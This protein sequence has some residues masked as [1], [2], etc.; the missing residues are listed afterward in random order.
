[1]DHYRTKC[2]RTA[3]FV[4]TDIEY[5]TDQIRAFGTPQESEERFSKDYGFGDIIPDNYVSLFKNFLIEID[6]RVFRY[7]AGEKNA[8]GNIKCHIAA[9]IV[10]FEK[11]K[12]TFVLEE[13]EVRPCAQKIGISKLILWQIVKSC[14]ASGCNFLV[15]FPV[16]QTRNILEG[17]NAR[18]EGLFL[19]QPD[20]LR[21]TPDGFTYNPKARTSTLLYQNLHFLEPSHFKIGHFLRSHIGSSKEI[22]YLKTDAFPTAHVMNYGLVHSRLLLMKRKQITD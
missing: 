4:D 11:S 13:I 8:G 6:N 18:F 5:K 16:E 19:Q 21:T 1:M 22:L 3:A 9:V 12:D 2:I 15:D 17:I 10:N 7:A 20:R 14:E